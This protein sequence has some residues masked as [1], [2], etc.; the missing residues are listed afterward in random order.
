MLPRR[1]VAV[2]V[3]SAAALLL[4]VGGSASRTPLDGPV[5]MTYWEAK[6]AGVRVP[7]LPSETGI[8]ACTDADFGEGFRTPAAGMRALAEYEARWG[9]DGGPGYCQVDPR[10]ALFAIFLPNA[11]PTSIFE[12]VAGK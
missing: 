7:P 12:P 2:L 5:F 8:R 9:E 6:E 4:A 10:T 3:A 1:G 11:R